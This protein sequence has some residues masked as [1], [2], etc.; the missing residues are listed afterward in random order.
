MAKTAN[1]NDPTAA[2][3]IP[4]DTGN[5]DAPT[6]AEKPQ[7]PVNGGEA[8]KPVESEYSAAELANA[9]RTRFGTPPEIVAAALKMAGKSKATLTEAQRIVNEFKERKVM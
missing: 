2:R 1:N 5:S 8:N 7:N 4:Q 6:G 3:E 9:A